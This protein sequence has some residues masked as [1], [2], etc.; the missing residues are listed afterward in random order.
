MEA[1]SQRANVCVCV[2]VC[3]LLWVLALAP[4]SALAIA[5]AFIQVYFSRDKIRH[6]RWDHQQQ[7]N[8][9]KYIIIS[10]YLYFTWVFPFSAHLFS[11]VNIVLFAPFHLSDC[12]FSGYNF[13][14]SENN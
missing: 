8:V 7:K 11:E 13:Q 9:T 12:Y 4:A 1:V 5:L 14:S 6:V 10:R 3:V 2:C